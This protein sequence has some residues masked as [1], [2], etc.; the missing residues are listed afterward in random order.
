MADSCAQYVNA[1][2]LKA[3][4]ESALHIEHVATSKDAAGNS[5]LVVTDPIRGQNYTNS[6]LDGLQHLYEQAISQA[7]YIT[8]K[9]FQLGAP[10]PN[11]EMT[12]PNQ[13]LQDETDGEYYR[14][15]GVFP[16]AVPEGSTPDSTG[17]IAV[18]AWV[19]VGDASLRSA[20]ATNSGAGLVGFALAGAYPNGTMGAYLAKES[21]KSTRVFHVDAY[22]A[23]GDGEEDDTPAI[24]KAINALKDAGSGTLLYSPGKTYR[25]T[26]TLFYYS[27]MIVDFNES[28]QFF[29]PPADA[30][31]WL[32][33]AYQAA[34]A[35]FTEN[36]I[37]RN[38]TV[39]TAS[40]KGNFIGTPGAR[41][42]LIENLTA[43]FIYWHLV[44]GSN[45]KNVEIRG[46]NATDCRSAA[47]QIE[48]LTYAA[49]VWGITSA[50]T[51]IYPA[52]LAD[53]SAYWSYAENWN[54]H[55]NTFGQGGT[56][57]GSGVNLHGGVTMSNIH[58]VNNKFNNFSVGVLI[59]SGEKRYVLVNGNFFLNC[60]RSVGMKGDMF[61]CM[62]H[63][64]MVRYA[65]DGGNY[66][67]F[68]HDP[69]VT[70][71]ASLADK[72]TEWISIKNNQLIGGGRT[73][74]NMQNIN[75]QLDISDNRISAL[76]TSFYTATTFPKPNGVDGGLSFVSILIKDCNNVVIQG[77][78]ANDLV[79]QAFASL[80]S[81]S[82][83]GT[84]RHHFH[85]NTVMYGGIAVVAQAISGTL[86]LKGNMVRGASSG[87][88]YDF[89]VDGYSD[90]F[91]SENTVRVAITGGLPLS[92]KNVATYAVIS[93]NNII[94]NSSQGTVLTLDACPTVKTSNNLVQG[95]DGGAALHISAINGTTL[96][97]FEPYMLASKITADGTS[98]K[99]VATVTYS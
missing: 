12:L 41:Y 31:A 93:N 75:G 43:G 27:N 55:H 21:I 48:S 11:N 99:L 92:F 17:G 89:A 76:S 39:K 29:D 28:T 53:N 58:I 59:D 45:G 86:S 57:E 67:H 4:K 94:S 82:F 61:G 65:L 25:Q 52:F 80:Y 2:D 9:S 71:I 77:N 79:A 66:S 98:T 56:Q 20:L 24:E 18:G 15:D 90:L 38:G 16:K 69:D 68:V 96:K 91:V 74:I 40:S 70:G 13:V 60:N 35:R 54:I 36:A 88:I 8:L 14:W 7:G 50:G 33:D 3:A 34:G 46:C 26:Y 73:P 84:V 10:L 62:I 6:T 22:G 64:N 32:P 44:D 87:S 47:I 19:S 78:T 30:S 72:P 83:A 49:G 63:D 37:F 23:V 85:D 5:A 95:F 97:A 42:L 1:D 81:S 51:L